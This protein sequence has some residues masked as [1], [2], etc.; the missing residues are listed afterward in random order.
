VEDNYQEFL[1]QLGP[2]IITA[3]SFLDL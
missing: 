1:L 2:K 3:W